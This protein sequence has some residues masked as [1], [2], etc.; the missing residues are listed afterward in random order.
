VTCA[1]TRLGTVSLTLGLDRPLLFVAAIIIIL[2]HLHLTSCGLQV[3]LL[4]L[5][6]RRSLRL[7]RG[8]GLG[9]RLSLRLRRLLLSWGCRCRLFSTLLSCEDARR[10]LGI[11]LRRA[12]SWGM[13]SG[14]RWM[15]VL[16]STS[17]VFCASHL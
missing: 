14:L 12:E 17:L 9:R 10:W 13:V 7:N 11:D 4:R 2:V 5:R 15:V 8:W 1:I 6:L 16:S 3:G